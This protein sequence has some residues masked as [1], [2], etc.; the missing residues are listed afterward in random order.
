MNV[1]DTAVSKAK[2]VAAQAL[3]QAPAEPR[4]H[5]IT[6]RAPRTDVAELFADARRLSV[7]FGD[8]ADVEETAPER[9][10]WTFTAGGE[11]QWD[12]A[13]AT[14]PSS[15]EF[16][17]LRPDSELRIT[18]SLRD[19][20][21]DWGTEVIARVSA[22]APGALA[23]PAINTALYRARALLQTGEVPTIAHN[24]SHRPSPR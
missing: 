19:A 12:C 20:P 13:V 10:R 1:L 8:V 14:G 17:D 11:P 2:E 16:A 5:A 15:V 3:S 18:L 24:P 9:Q 6:I 22:P 7:I 21:N 4:S 23:G